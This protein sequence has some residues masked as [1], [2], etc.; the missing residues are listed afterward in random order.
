MAS[1]SRGNLREHVQKQ[2]R[3]SSS[4]GKGTLGKVYKVQGFD[5]EQ[6]ALKVSGFIDAT[7]EE[8]RYL[9]GEVETLSRF[10]HPHIVRHI[11]GWDTRDKQGQLRVYILMEY[12]P[13][14]DLRS[15]L[16][17]TLGRP[18]P[19]AEFG[20]WLAQIASGLDFI[21][22]MGVLHRNVKTPN[23]M[24]GHVDGH[25]TLKIGDFGMSKMLLQ[26]DAMARSQVGTPYFM[27]PEILNGRQYNMKTDIW[28]LGCTAYE[29]AT[30]TTLFQAQTITTL[31]SGINKHKAA[32]VTKQIKYGKFFQMLIGDMLHQDPKAR[33]DAGE[34]LTR[35]LDE[36]Y[37][38]THLG[39]TA[40]STLTSTTSS[41]GSRTRT[42]Q[43][44]T[45]SKVALWS[46]MDS[47][48]SGVVSD[49]GSMVI[50]EDVSN[51]HWCDIDKNDKVRLMGMAVVPP[52]I[53]R[54]DRRP[55]TKSESDMDLGLQ[56][57]TEIQRKKKLSKSVTFDRRV[58]TSVI[59]EVAGEDTEEK[60]E[61]K[62]EELLSSG[63]KG[64]ILCQIGKEQ[65]SLAQTM[66]EAV[67]TAAFSKLN[68]R[69]DA[70]MERE[71]ASVLGD[72]YE[73][74]GP[75]FVVLR[76]LERTFADP[77]EDGSQRKRK[78]LNKTI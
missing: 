24:V 59:P 5:G 23:I 7:A 43:G 39:M 31:L 45:D 47:D 78:S 51:P 77:Q 66:G 14:G 71:L 46:R 58:S 17:N 54:S 28:S 72:Q 15:Y 67:F 53:P 19:E 38:T 42:S 73:E 74:F 9:L 37:K 57:F 61:G 11:D 8:E 33:P 26:P 76:A 22:T 49:A 62:V 16:N 12:C 48:T 20:T 40:S 25:V 1:N 6:Y 52:V 69:T 10:Q 44:Q 55:R 36:G 30:L 65:S 41:T 56:A 34:I 75:R 27:S 70:K 64:R 35:L 29:M 2:L 68:I 63:D 3:S 50:R 60:D 18:P 32:Q 4:V 21:H 13:G